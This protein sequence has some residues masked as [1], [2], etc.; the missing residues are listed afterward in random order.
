VLFL[1]YVANEASVLEVMGPI[2]DRI[3]GAFPIDL[4]FVGDKV[5]GF[6]N[7]ASPHV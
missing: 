7:E 4:L 6:F 5:E 1:S 2:L 3:I